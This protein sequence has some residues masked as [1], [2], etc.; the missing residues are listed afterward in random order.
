MYLSNFIIGLIC[1]RLPS[2]P[3]EKDV[4][5]SHPMVGNQAAMERP[6]RIVLGDRIWA[7]IR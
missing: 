6:G 4:L 1:L 7:Q 3:A 2:D 5:G